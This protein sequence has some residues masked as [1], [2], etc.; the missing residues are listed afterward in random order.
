[1]EENKCPICDRRTINREMCYDCLQDFY[2]DFGEIEEN[3]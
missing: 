3:N 2:A 1:M